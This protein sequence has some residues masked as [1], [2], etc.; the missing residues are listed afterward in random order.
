MSKALLNNSSSGRMLF[1]VILLLIVLCSG[2]GDDK[3]KAT[4][5]SI[6]SAVEKAYDH[7]TD[8]AERFH[9]LEGL[10]EEFYWFS[11]RVTY[12]KGPLPSFRPFMVYDG[13]YRSIP[14]TKKDGSFLKSESM[15][16][17]KVLREAKVEKI[18]ETLSVANLGNRDTRYVPM[19]MSTYG[20]GG[21]KDVWFA[22]VTHKGKTFLAAICPS[23]DAAI[24]EGNYYP[25]WEK[26]FGERVRQA[27]EEQI[28]SRAQ[29]KEDERLAAEAKARDERLLPLRQQCAATYTRDIRSGFAVISSEI[30]EETNR[31]SWEYYAKFRVENRGKEDIRS[32]T[33]LLTVLNTENIPVYSAQFTERGQTYAA[34]NAYI[35]QFRMPSD[36]YSSLVQDSR[37]YRALIFKKV[38]NGEYTARL[39]VYDFQV[40][41]K[42]VPTASTLLL[43]KD[44]EGTFLLAGNDNGTCTYKGVVITPGKDIA[45]PATEL[46]QTSREAINGENSVQL[47]YLETLKVE[48]AEE[49]KLLMEKVTV[50]VTTLNPEQKH[51]TLQFV[52]TNN[53]PEEIEDPEVTVTF[54]ENGAILGS[55][56][57]RISGKAPAGGQMEM[58]YGLANS[59]YLN[60]ADFFTG[61]DAIN[62]LVDGFVI[63]DKKI[64]KDAT[65]SLPREFR[66]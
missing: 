59:G 48:L 57:I 41:G 21:G 61:S 54:L 47:A 24:E 28:R 35:K 66:R 29:R 32:A 55:R 62:A 13:G 34:G 63:K 58:K 7:T 49:N 18:S 60:I 45:E 30:L 17:P 2:C 3:A 42:S 25:A 6:A 65:A 19:D 5:E 33:F 14:Y 10:L 56:G 36:M 9:D 40:S 51:P 46:P 31:D 52:I 12:F 26:E 44:G 38:M 53:L 27:K 37:R 23:R 4:M 39:S 64:S 11:L 1:P 15:W 16:S 50:V 8:T 43:E 20:D 22:L